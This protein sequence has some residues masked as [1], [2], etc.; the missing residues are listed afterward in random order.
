MTAVEDGN[1]YILN[2]EKTWISNGGIAD[3]YTVFARTGE[4]PGA[5]GLSAFVVTPDLPGFDVVERLKVMAP[6]PLAHLRFSDM[7]VPKSALIGAAGAG[8]KIAMSVLDVFRSTVAAAALG[9]ARR[10]LDEALARVTARHIRDAPMADLQMVQ[11]H[12]ADM[13][14]DVD[15]SALLIYRAAWAKDSGAPRVTREAA[16]AKLFSTDQA[17]SVIDRAVQLHGGDGVRVQRIVIAR[18]TLAEFQ[19]GR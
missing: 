2:G 18:Q 9:F 11:G 3:V 10:A 7:R 8:F 12:I 4:A 13:A 5:R 19:G 15:A 17:Q 1:D 16:M 14:V 6:H